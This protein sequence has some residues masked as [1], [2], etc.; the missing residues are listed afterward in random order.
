MFQKLF[1]YKRLFTCTVG[2]SL[3]LFLLIRKTPSPPTKE[4]LSL[5][6]LIRKSS[7]DYG[8]TSSRVNLEKKDITLSTLKDTMGLYIRPIHDPAPGFL[9]NYPL[10][11]MHRGEYII[12]MFTKEY[13]EM[14]DNWYFTLESC[15]PEGKAVSL[16]TP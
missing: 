6:E 15:G 10:V 13:L 7:R 1:G 3:G 12:P 16:F 5:D 2:A 14:K 11:F 9:S 4:S 8:L